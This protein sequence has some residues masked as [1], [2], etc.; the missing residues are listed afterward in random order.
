MPGPVLHL[1]ATVLCAHGG[2][3]QPTAVSPRVLVNGMPAVTLGPPYTVAG[4]PFATSQPQP[5]LTA[6]WTSGAVRVTSLGAPLLV[7]TGQAVC[8][9]NGTPVVVAAVQTRVIAT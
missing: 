9:P 2:Q 6:Q 7:Q 4:C 3:A 8:A 1:G 5:C